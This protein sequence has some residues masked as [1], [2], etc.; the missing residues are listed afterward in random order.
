[1]AEAAAEEEERRKAKRGLT[2]RIGGGLNYMYGVDAARNE[3]FE[4]DFVD[5]YALGM[6]GYTANENQTGKG[7]FIGAFVTVGNTTERG[8]TK[9]LEDSNTGRTADAEIA[10]N[11][12][13][14]A[15]LGIVFFETLRLSTGT[16]YQSYTLDNDEKR[17]FYYSTTGGL[18]FGGRFI[19]LTAD[20]NFL[21][22]RQL[23]ATILRPTVGLLL[24][25]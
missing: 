14:Q 22:G 7:T 1:A 19:K 17:L 15:E 18:Q 13:Y 3:N 21:Y 11:R 6:L 10:D 20:I 8:I 16:G 2:L 4:S 24:Q 25:L 5:W 23:E 12:F 9:F